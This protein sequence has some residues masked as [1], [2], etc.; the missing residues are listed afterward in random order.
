MIRYGMYLKNGIDL[1]HL[2]QQETIEKAKQYFAKVKQMPLKEFNKFNKLANI[3]NIF[4][5]SHLRF[6]NE[7][8]LLL[9]I[10]RLILGFFNKCEN[11]VKQ[12][13]MFKFRYNALYSRDK[14]AKGRILNCLKEVSRRRHENKIREI[15]VK[16]VKGRSYDDKEIRNK[17]YCDWSR[18]AEFIKTKQQVDIILIMRGGGNTSG[19]SDSFDTIELFESIRN[20]NVPIITAIGHAADKGDN[21]LITEIVEK[22]YNSREQLSKAI[23]RF[24]PIELAMKA[25]FDLFTEKAPSIINKYFNNEENIGKTVT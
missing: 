13:A 23:S 12:S 10:M 16:L 9:Y 17:F 3:E 7:K 1:I 5:S 18:K 25:K 6:L 19:M 4:R 21:L 22:T 24:L 14:A 2:T 15:M 20:S 8:T 11:K